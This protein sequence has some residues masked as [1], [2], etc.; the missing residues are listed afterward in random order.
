M[1]GMPTVSDVASAAGVSRQTVSNVLNS[2]HVVKSDTRQRVERAIEELGYRP[3]A[4]ARRLRTRRSSTIGIRLD[5]VADGISG[6]VLDRYVHALTEQAAAR[7]M[8]ILL[9]TARTPDDEIAQFRSLTEGADVDAFVLTSTYYGDP[10]TGW[11]IEHNVPFATF[12]RPWGEDDLDDPQHLWV[13]VDGAAGTATATEHALEQGA[14]RVGFLGWPRTSGTGDD[15]E[16]GWRSALAVHGLSAEGLRYTV[17]DSVPQARRAMARVLAGE[18]RPDALVCVSD[19]LA[20]GAHLAA[21]DLGQHELLIVGFDNTP[22]AEALGFA[23]VEQ[24]PEKVA[25]GTLELLMGQEG[26]SIDSRR[27]QSGSAHVLVT[28][29]LVRR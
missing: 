12:G 17:E 3:H 20:F 28:P 5:P 6:A 29:R 10:R 21:A 19:S 18:S 22:V 25:A 2:P 4:S 24:M 8:R 14:R 16:R 11:L 13:D 27:V 1:A 9:Y 7:G 23:S 15:R 26:T